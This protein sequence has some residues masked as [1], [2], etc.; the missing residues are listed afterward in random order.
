MPLGGVRQRAVLAR[1]A[2]AYPEP[3]G[4]ETLRDA[5]WGDSPPQQY[6]STLHAYISR[7]RKALAPHVE[8]LAGAAGYRLH[9]R[10]AHLD[11]AEFLAAVHAAAR[12]AAAG[13]HGEVVVGIEAALRLWTSS[14][15]LQPFA[16]EPWAASFCGELDE[17]RAQAVELLAGAYLETNVPEAAVET[18]APLVAAQPLRE[19]AARL[20]MTALYRSGRQADALEVYARVRRTLDD[21]LGLAPSPALEATFTQV[22]RQDPGLDWAPDPRTH[23]RVLP[24]R[25]AWLVGRDE[26]IVAVEAALRSAGAVVVYGLP[27]VGKT[28]LAAEIAHR[29]EGVVGWVPAED[30]T[31]LGA[32]IELAARLGVSP[33][34]SGTELL[35]A[36][37]RR[38]DER[39][40]WLLVFDNAEQAEPLRSW[41]PPTRS[42]TVLVTSRNPAWAWLGPARKL[43]PLAPEAA[44]AFIR[45]RAGRAAGDEAPLAEAMGGIALALEQACSYIDETRMSIARYLSIYGRRRMDLLARGAPA[46]HPHPVTTT[47]DMVL[48]NIRHRSRLAV[49]VLEVG[50]FLSGDDLPVGLFEDASGP[51]HRDELELEDAVA[52][53][54]RY[55][56]VDRDATTLRLHRFVQELIRTS[57]SPEDRRERAAEAARIV[58]SRVPVDPGSLIE[59]RTAWAPL[60]P[61]VLALLRWTPQDAVTDDLIRLTVDCFR[62]LR[63]RLALGPAHEL[64]DLAFRLSGDVWA[65]EPLVAVELL[66][67]RAD[68]LDAE[69]H[70]G[71]AQLELSRAMTTLSRLVDV[72]DLVTARLRSLGGH[73]LNCA[74]RPIEAVA[75]YEQA[76]PVLHRQGRTTET[77]A[78]YIGL[79]YSRWSAR[80]Y[81]GAADEFRT[82]LAV[83]TGDDWRRHP[84]HAEALSGLGMMLHEQGSVEAALELQSTALAESLEL[85]GEVDHPV[86]A[87]THDK[88]G[89]EHGLVGHHEESLR[90]HQIAADMLARLFGL[91]DPRLAMVISNR[92]LAEEACGLVEQARESQRRALDVLLN[93]YG[94]SHR[95][96]RLVTERLQ[97]LEARATPPAPAAAEPR[98][99]PAPVALLR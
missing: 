18:L 9:L 97:A 3:V 85:Y 88:M 78:A 10:D 89:W 72:P 27:G 66:G 44:A 82:A 16:D 75:E 58:R 19:E 22:L 84:L 39:P 59:E 95:D 79:G 54:V 36:L 61:H 45:R 63:T 56:I 34:L 42:G 55:S 60:V 28:T 64:V 23:A 70:L 14:T 83:M 40:G 69:G 25:P 91:D 90:H 17:A 29:H 30:T 73:L 15:P 38:L 32:L 51:D 33:L 43:E 13:R 71:E 77:V 52:E 93:Q 48:E 7:L 92:G 81:T 1:L 31:G 65:R 5:V 68:L 11:S 41:I 74:D 98:E 99:Q 86:I 46:D 96:T 94:P 20:L 37:W 35:Q 80:D 47:W 12:A 26:D 76:L 21:D 24:P 53:L 4:L 87:Y 2:V 49:S 62:Y 67:C 6:V 8:V 57:L 50:S